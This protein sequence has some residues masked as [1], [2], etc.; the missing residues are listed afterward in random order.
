M[1]DTYNVSKTS[2]NSETNIILFSNT[3]H[4][5]NQDQAFEVM[6]KWDN[7]FLTGKAWTGKTFLTQK[8]IQHLKSK[9]KHVIVC[10]PTG[11]AALNIGGATIHST[12]K[13]IGSYPNVYERPPKRQKVKWMHIDCLIIDEI[14]MVSP[15][16][17]DYIDYLLQQERWSSKPF[18]W[19]QVILVWDPYQLPPVHT[20][21]TEKDIAIMKLL[22]NKYGEDLTFD[23]AHC[24]SEFRTLELSEVKR[25]EDPKFIELL[26]KIRH[27]DLSVLDQFNSG[28]GDE[29][30]VHLRPFNKMVDSFN[31]NRMV[32][33]PWEVKNYVARVNGLFDQQRSVTPVLLQ[34]KVGARVM[35][36]ANQAD[37]ELVNG[38]LGTV[39][40]MWDDHVFVTVDRYW[41]TQF[42]LEPYEWKQI[43]YEG[44]EETVIGTFS[45]IPLKLG[46]CMTIHKSQGLSL[47]SVSI[48]VNAKMA[49]D[50][51]YVGLSRATT[52]EKLY[53]NRV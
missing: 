23:K 11:V 44:W 43:E 53:V 37:L 30:T 24:F 9:K 36:T 6:Q 49:R 38:D 34:L 7:C 15:D 26:N 8:Y 21:Y 33:L 5:M 50:L 27:W 31:N 29:H 47:E 1:N 40:S 45:Q 25:Q 52:F 13:M 22:H 10:A 51:V 20:T 3:Y 42:K 4:I 35:V 19:I 2:K 48:T 39:V 46:W 14:S 41:D 28:Y 12:F 17:L 32:S 18:G 16:Y